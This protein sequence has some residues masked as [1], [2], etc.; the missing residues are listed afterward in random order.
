[1]GKR[2][3]CAPK[4]LCVWSQQSVFDLERLSSSEVHTNFRRWLRQ[5]DV[6]SGLPVY[7]CCEPDQR[8]GPLL[9][10]DPMFRARSPC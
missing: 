2:R 6:G 8:F 7:V 1:M 3:N 5:R 4:I 10:S 9:A